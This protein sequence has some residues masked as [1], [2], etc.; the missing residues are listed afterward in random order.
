MREIIG[1]G[2]ALLL[3]PTF[4]IQTYRQW[5]DRHQPVH[6]IGV[7]FF[8]LALAGTAG[9]V[10]YSWMVGNTVYFALNSVL[11]VTNAIGLAIAVYRWRRNTRSPRGF[12]GRPDVDRASERVRIKLS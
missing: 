2:S 11:V 3:L 12:S 7:W 1:W 10:V 6:A 9:Q 4:G 5:H 8:V